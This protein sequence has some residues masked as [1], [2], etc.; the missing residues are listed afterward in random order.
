[1]KKRNYQ[2]DNICKVLNEYSH[3]ERYKRYKRRCY[4]NLIVKSLLTFSLGLIVSAI[5]K[6][7]FQ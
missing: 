5:F 1:M 2:T 6:M 7:L 3:E 4:R